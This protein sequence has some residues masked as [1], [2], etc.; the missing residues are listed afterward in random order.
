M[1]IFLEQA[2]DITCSYGLLG[3]I[4]HF[5]DLGIGSSGTHGMVVFKGVPLSRIVKISESIK[6]TFSDSWILI[7]DIFFGKFK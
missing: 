1:S 7:P 4:F 5:G 3:R 6:S 2:E